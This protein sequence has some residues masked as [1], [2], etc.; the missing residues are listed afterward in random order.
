MK[1]KNSQYLLSGIRHRKFG[2]ALVL[3]EV[4]NEM[5]KVHKRG[6]QKKENDVDYEHA[7]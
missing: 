1:I 4:Y 7:L 5:Y 6:A 2:V 3:N